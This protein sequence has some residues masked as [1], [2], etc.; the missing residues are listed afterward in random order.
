M[1][2]E[3]PGRAGRLGMALPDGADGPGAGP[4]RCCSALGANPIPF[5]AFTTSPLLV[6][7]VAEPEE[8]NMRQ[9]D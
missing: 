8:S 1:A 4:G 2:L 3:R 7:D 9:G 5:G 6:S